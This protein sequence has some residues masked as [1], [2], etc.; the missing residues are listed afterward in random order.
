MRKLV[1][2]PPMSTAM[3]ASRGNPCT[4]IPTSEVVPPTST[5]IASWG[6]DRKAAP[7][8]LFVGPEAKVRTG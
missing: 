6:P 1:R 8:M 5:T 7:R 3:D 2:T 4:S